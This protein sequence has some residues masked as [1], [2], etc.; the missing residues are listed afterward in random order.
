MSGG[1]DRFPKP[2]SAKIKMGRKRDRA[3]KQRLSVSKDSKESVKQAAVA[4]TCLVRRGRGRRE[5][6]VKEQV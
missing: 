1:G 3:L 4:E 5:T 6:G 2:S